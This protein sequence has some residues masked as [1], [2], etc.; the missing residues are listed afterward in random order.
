MSFWNS[1][2]QKLELEENEYLRDYDICCAIE[3]L[4]RLCED[5]ASPR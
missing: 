2:H 4:G 1:N 5:P 3:L